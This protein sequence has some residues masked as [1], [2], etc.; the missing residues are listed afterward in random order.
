MNM[1]NFALMI[2]IWIIGLLFFFT[3]YSSF[4]LSQAKPDSNILRQIAKGDQRACR[5]S[6]AVTKIHSFYGYDIT[7]HRFNYYVD[8]SVR[9]LRGSVTTYFKV[10]DNGFQQISFKL[11]TSLSVD[12]VIFHEQVMDF[13]HTSSKQLAISLGEMLHAG[14]TDSIIVYYQGV[15]DMGDG[16]G[17]FEQA[18]HAGEPVIWTQSEPYTA[19]GWWPCKDGLDDKIDSID[20]VVT[21]PARYRVAGNGLLVEEK[22][23]GPDKIYHWK[24]RY[25]I[26]PYLIAFAVTN[27]ESYSDWCVTGTDS[28]EVL[29]YVYPENIE[30]A[31]KGTG[32]LIGVMQYFIQRFGPYPFREEKYGHAQFSHG[33]GMENQTMSFMGG[34][35]FEI[36]SHEL[37]HSWFGNMITCASWHE[38]WLNEG[39]ATYCAGLAYERFSPDLYWPIWKNN[40]ISYITQAPDGA[41]YVADTTSVARIFSARLSYSKGAFVLHMLRWIMGDEHFFSAIHDYLTDPDLA[42]GFASTADLK[43][44]MEEASGLDL[45]GFFDDWYTGEGYPSYTLL[46]YPLP[47]SQYQLIIHQKQSHP[48]VEFFEMPLPVRFKNSTRDT[49][50]V[51]DHHYSGEA[52]VVDP[53]FVADSILFDPDLWI[54]SRGNSVIINPPDDSRD[55]IQMIPN[56]TDHLLQVITQTLEIE[57]LML[58]DLSGRQLQVPMVTLLPRRSVSVDLSDCPSGTY[59][60]KI[61]TPTGIKSAKVIKID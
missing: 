38:I 60:L 13:Q 23:V 52:F 48:S 33:G 36:S 3:I 57:S 43:R 14:Q 59:L 53:G 26:V 1:I 49:L 47:D 25:P 18:Y 17:S 31:R 61:H 29:N 56:P 20:M 45:T 51:L 34:F 6:P 42:Y 27:Y 11:T 16:F 50:I 39:F 2:R 15:P 24:H 4:V 28:V 21:T 41:V 35:G 40:N 10:I 58:F 22:E 12:S 46:C 9:Y 5:F 44:H 55:A 7:Y 37:A 30:N 8:P 32:D 54:V 19:P